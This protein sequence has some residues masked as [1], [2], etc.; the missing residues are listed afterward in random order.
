MINNKSET[1]IRN[2]GM[3]ILI[4]KLG[5]VDAERFVTSIIREPFDYTNWQSDLMKEM[6]VREVSAKAKDYALKTPG[7]MQP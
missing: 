5:K 7:A 6:T 2:E 4:E 3:N 1:A